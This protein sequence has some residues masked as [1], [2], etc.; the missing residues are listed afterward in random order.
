[1][2]EEPEP[3]DLDPEKVAYWYFRLNGFLQI[4]NFILHDARGNGQR[5]DADLLAVRFPH[6]A[7]FIF[8]QELPMKDDEEA[9]HLSKAHIDI[10]IAEITVN[11]PCKLNGPWTKPERQNMHR[12]LAAVGCVPTDQID[13]VAADLYATGCYAGPN[14]RV[15]LVSIGGSRN[16]DLDA[17]FPSVTQLTWLDV[18]TF[19]WQRFQKYRKQKTQV[20]QW[21]QCGKELLWL[22]TGRP[23]QRRFIDEALARM[24]ARNMI[25]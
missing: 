25:Q 14:N 23:D 17:R 8:D 24:G 11:R 2:V 1:M 10:V 22:A 18:L 16:P 5:T 3:P 4:E 21:D 12:V 19:I 6:R 7:E 15:R 9:L 20:D 13:G